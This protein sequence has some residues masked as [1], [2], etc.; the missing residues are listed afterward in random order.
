M[1]IISYHIYSY[2]FIYMYGVGGVVIVE[3]FL[4]GK[5]KEDK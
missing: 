5:V 3:N 4:N 1:D 2:I